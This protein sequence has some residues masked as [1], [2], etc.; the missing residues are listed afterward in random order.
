MVLS[1]LLR[2]I[3]RWGVSHLL[4]KEQHMPR[5]GRFAPGGLV[6][7]VLNRANAGVRCFQTDGD[8]RAFEQVLAESVARVRLELFAYVLMPNHWHLVLRPRRDGDLAQF[9]HRMTITHV[10]RW[11]GQRETAGLGHLYQGTYKSFAIQE[12]DHFLIVCRYVERNPLRAGLVARAQEWPWGSLWVR[13]QTTSTSLLSAWPVEPQA[14]WESS[15]NTPQTDSE[16][17]R[18]RKSVVSGHPFGAEAWRQETARSL[19]IPMAGPRGSPG[20]CT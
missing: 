9:M 11:H 12:D 6:F 10:R 4:T 1:T 14:D 13:S 15:V 7:H 8:Y 5:S 20:K 17:A 2:N 18:L 16:L 19:S 3:D